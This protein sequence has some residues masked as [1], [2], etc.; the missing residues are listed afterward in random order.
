VSTAA[1][2]IRKGP[3]LTAAII[4]HLP[5]G[6]HVVGEAVSGAWVKITYNGTSGWV[7]SS[8]LQ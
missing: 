8:L 7:H 5:A 1:V 3:D 6:T 2:R 4:G